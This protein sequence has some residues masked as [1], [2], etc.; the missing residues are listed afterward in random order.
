MLYLLY[1]IYIN[2]TIKINFM[3]KMN[4]SKFQCYSTIKESKSKKTFL[5]NTKEYF[6][7]LEWSY[8]LNRTESRNN[9]GQD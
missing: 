6:I 9:K 3:Q 7:D 8:F 4:M 5:G 2:L 1:N